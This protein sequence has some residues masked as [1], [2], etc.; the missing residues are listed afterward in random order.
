CAWKG[1]CSCSRPGW[2][3]ERRC[4]CACSRRWPPWSRRCVRRGSIRSRRCGSADAS[5]G[6]VLFRPGSELHSLVEL[7]ERQVGADLAQGKDG[8]EPLVDF[9]DEAALPPAI[10][11]HRRAVLLHQVEVLAGA[12]A[13]S[14]LFPGRSTRCDF[15]VGSPWHSTTTLQ[16]VAT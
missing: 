2:R 7:R 10:S 14:L 6:F 13:V 1:R 9:P 11:R 12:H 16:A 15:L 3:W 4:W 5:I 8:V